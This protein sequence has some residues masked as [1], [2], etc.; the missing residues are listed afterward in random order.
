QTPK[1]SYLRALTP[2]QGQSIIEHKQ[3]SV[4][5]RSQNAKVVVKLPFSARQRDSRTSSIQS[6]RA[7]SQPLSVS[8]SRICSVSPG[9]FP[10]AE[11]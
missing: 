4:T 9:T 11:I 1:R 10:T 2:F 3:Q 8:E 5:R 6:C 7:Q